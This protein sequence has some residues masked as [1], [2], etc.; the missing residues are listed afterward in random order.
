MKTVL[1]LAVSI[2]AGG[3]VFALLARKFGSDC[4]P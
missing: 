4:I 1:V 2:L 3:G